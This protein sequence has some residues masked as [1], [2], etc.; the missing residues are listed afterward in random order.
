MTL[1]NNEAA[2]STQSQMN[3]PSLLRMRAAN[4]PRL[5]FGQDQ[6]QPRVLDNKCRLCRTPQATSLGSSFLSLPNDFV[7]SVAKNPFGAAVALVAKSPFRTAVAAKRLPLLTHSS[8]VL[9]EALNTKLRPR[10][11]GIVSTTSPAAFVVLLLLVERLLE[12]EGETLAQTLTK[13]LELEWLRISCHSRFQN[14]LARS[15]S[16]L[17][18][19]CAETVLALA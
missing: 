5:L 4:L 3:L 2:S 16:Q 9:P 15:S 8:R 11:Y 6:F 13:P 18:P 12:H 7:A 10:G 1:A 14:N 19:R 17:K